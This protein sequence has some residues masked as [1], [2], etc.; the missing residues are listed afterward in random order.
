[1]LF[2]DYKAFD[3]WKFAYPYLYLGVILLDMLL[4]TAM[5]PLRY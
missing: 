2:Y 1:M 5:W 4:P 3:I